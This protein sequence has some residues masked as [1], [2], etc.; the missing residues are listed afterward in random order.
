MGGL[1]IDFLRIRPREVA[2]VPG[3]LNDA[4]LKPVAQSQIGDSVPAGV[5]HCAHLSLCA[6]PAEP[7]CHYDAVRIAQKLPCTPRFDV[8]RVDPL[9]VYAG[10]V[11]NRAV[12]Y[13]L[14]D[15]DVRIAI[16]HVLADHRYRDHTLRMSE[17]V[18][19]LLPLSE[20]RLAVVQVQL[21]DHQ[22]GETLRLKP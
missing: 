20:I 17:P 1:R 21:P 9:D 4:H 16:R 2:D 7:P 19:N 11:S 12:L 10:I 22:L 5:F 18:N 13:C 15:A 6:A 3:E 8:L 14:T